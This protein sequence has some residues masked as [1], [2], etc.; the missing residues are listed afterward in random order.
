MVASAFV[1]FHLLQQY[2]IVLL[3]GTLLYLILYANNRST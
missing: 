3:R 2:S 1:S